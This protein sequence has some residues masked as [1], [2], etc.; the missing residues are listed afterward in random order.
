MKA[1]T[2][3]EFLVVLAA[4]LSFL[5]VWVGMAASTGSRISSSLDSRDVSLAVKT[6]ASDADSICLMAVGSRIEVELI[7]PVET[8]LAANGNNLVASW[9]NESVSYPTRCKVFTRKVVYGNEKF[10]LERGL[11]GVYIT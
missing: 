4:M 3:L 11:L 5:A 10:T 6:L 8:E 9:G 7:F 2:S 1:Q